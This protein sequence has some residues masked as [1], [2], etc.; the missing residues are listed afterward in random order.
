MAWVEKMLEPIDVRRTPGAH[1]A[2]A[3]IDSALAVV[4]RAWLVP[5]ANV[6]DV[7]RAASIGIPTP[8]VVDG[9]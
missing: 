1:F 6:D 7:Q 4:G 9:A 8:L 5:V 3:S 2:V